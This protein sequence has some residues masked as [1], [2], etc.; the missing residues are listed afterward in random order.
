MGST[1]VVE[2]FSQ[3]FAV[4]GMTNNPYQTMVDKYKQ[5]FQSE[6]DQLSAQLANR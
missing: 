6:I 1:E 4:K 5:I 3:T 2:Y